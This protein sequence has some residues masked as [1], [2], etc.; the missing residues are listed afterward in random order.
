MQVAI[1]GNATSRARQ[2]RI[3]GMLAYVQIALNIAIA[4]AYTPFMV[5]TLGQAEYGLFAIAGAMAS[6]L[7]ILDMGLADSV[8]RRLVGLHGKDDQQGERDFLG[9]MLSLYG[10]LAMAVLAAAAVAILCVPLLFGS[11][12]APDALRTLQLML[13]PL[14]ISTAVV[15]AG[16]P[17][18]ATLV[19]HE[20]F[21]FLRSLE[22]VV[23]VLV[24]A[25]NVAALLLGG[26]VLAVV[27]I[28]SCGAICATTAK[29]LM[30]RSG[31]GL[32]LAPRRVDRLQ[33]RDMSSYAAPIFVAMLVEQ[34]FW[35]L[36]SILIGAR[37]GAAAVA[38]YAIGVMFN[39]YFMAFATAISR[40]LMPDLVR[41]IDAGSDGPAL[42]ARLVEISRWQALVLMLVL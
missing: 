42:T 35:K 17:L 15:V 29:W 39:K 21:V 10:V 33:V 11:T 16:N 18:N 9:S 3:G 27:V 31:L 12:M 1:S 20:R 25:A 5:R 23:V 40:V 38:V 34:I 30:I 19:A 26:G 28:S 2:R 13:V 6:Y 8:V 41:R 4:L 32:P 7:V 24:T 22:M 37:L 36:D 14:G